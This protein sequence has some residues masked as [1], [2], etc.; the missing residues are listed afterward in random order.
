[1]NISRTLL[2]FWWDGKGD[3]IK[4]N[5]MISHCEDRGLKIINIRLFPQALKLS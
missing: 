1:M 4:R 2:K 3:K 5:V